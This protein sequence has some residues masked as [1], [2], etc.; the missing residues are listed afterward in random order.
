MTPYRLAISTD[1]LD[2]DGKVIYGDIGLDA[3]TAA[4][5]DWQWVTADGHAYAAGQLDDFD[6]VWIL[7]HSGIAAESLS[8]ASSLRH[9]ARFGAGYD[10]I[11]LAACSEGGVLVTNA[12]HGV[13][14]PMVHTAVTLLFALGHNLLA[15]DRLA[16]TGDWRANGALRGRGLQNATVGVIGLG[17]I[18]AA[19]AETLTAMGLDVVA[20]NRTPRPE[21]GIT[22]LGLDELLATS[23][24]V[25]ITISAGPQ[26]RHFIGADQLAAMKPGSFLINIARGSVV[27]ED[28]LVA[29]LTSGPLAGAGLDVFATEPLPASSPLTALDNVILGPHSLCWTDSYATDTSAEARQCLLDVAAGRTP[30]NVVNPEVWPAYRRRFGPVGATDR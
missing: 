11:D 19:T 16:R 2:A 15:K 7:G 25:I 14:T 29:A 13:R 12:P 30:Q 4:G 24:Y 26:T 20:Y 8:A 10:Q 17:G 21:L 27:D 1:S 28:A 3:L 22:Q 23:D 18:G 6:A 9:V 5:V